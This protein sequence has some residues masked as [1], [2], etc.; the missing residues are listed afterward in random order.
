MTTLELKTEI[1][2]A[3]D[4]VPDNALQDVLNYLNTVQH[5]SPDKKKLYEFIDKVF[6]EDAEVLRRLAE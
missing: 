1:H 5:P 4:N 2:K 6:E 3:I